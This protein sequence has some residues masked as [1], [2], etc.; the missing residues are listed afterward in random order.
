MKYLTQEGLRILNEIKTPSIRGTLAAAA[1]R[2]GTKAI[3]S[4][5]KVSGR[6]DPV[7]VTPTEKLVK[8]PKSSA[9]ETGT[10]PAAKP[11]FDDQGRLI[12]TNTIYTRRRG[13]KDGKGGYLVGDLISVDRDR[14]MEAQRKSVIDDIWAREKEKKDKYKASWDEWNAD[15]AGRDMPLQRPKDHVYNRVMDLSKTNP[16]LFN[17]ADAES[18]AGWSP[19]EK[20]VRKKRGQ[21]KEAGMDPAKA[22]DIGAIAAHKEKAADQRRT[23][24]H[25]KR[26]GWMDWASRASGRP[27]EL[28][29]DVKSWVHNKPGYYGASRTEKNRE[30]GLFWDKYYPRTN[31]KIITLPKFKGKGRKPY[32][33]RNW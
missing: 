11:E 17:A 24:I 18:F 8:P 33:D 20:E 32:W 2:V 16:D 14:E 27:K 1:A 6:Q 5:P 23:A 21:A 30:G 25:K 12:N 10:K 26:S 22:F 31:P 29:G 19:L 9:R 3:N 4:S 13:S 15:R 28:E 7:K